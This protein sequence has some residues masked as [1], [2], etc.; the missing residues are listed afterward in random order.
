M[1]GWMP[2][3]GPRSSRPSD[4]AWWASPPGCSATT[5]RPRTSC[6]R[7]GCGCTGPTRARRDREPA[8][9]ADHGHDPVVPG[10]AAGPH[11]GAGRGGRAAG[12]RSRPGRRRRPGRHRRYRPAG[13]ASTGSHRASGSPSCCTTASASSSPRS[14]PSSTPHPSAARKLAS[15]ARAKVTQPAPED[16]A[17]RL[18]GGR[19]LHGRGSGGRLRPAAAAARA[20]RGGGR[21]RRRGPGRHARRGS[22]VARRWPRSS[23][24]APSPRSPVFVGDRPGCRVVPPR[25]GRR[26]SSTSTVTDGLVRADHLPRRARRARAVVRR[27]ARDRKYRSHLPRGPTVRAVSSAQYRSAHTPAEG[28][29][30]EDHDLPPARRTV[31]PRPP[32][33]D[34]TTTSSTPRTATSRRPRR[35]G[36]TTHQAGARGHE[37][38]LAAPEEVAGL[39]QRR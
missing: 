4:R 9:L 8:G 36:D 31:R 2:W 25:R 24:A 34:R 21:R 29:D 12:H 19:R 5:P 32:R 20:R 10:P 18:G 16:R 6:S 37:G 17:G 13:R 33:R 39:V 38:P 15:R 26:W 11:P 22:R 23:T 30:H 7:R 27:A 14:P 3:T 1:Q 35:T 28:D